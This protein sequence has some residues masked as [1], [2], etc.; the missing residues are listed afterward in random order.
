MNNNLSLGQIFKSKTAWTAVLAA[1]LNIWNT[2]SG[3][4]PPKV[5]VVG[6]AVLGLI[7]VL[8]RAFPTQEG[9]QPPI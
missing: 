1:T 2:T 4:L 7:T 6:N 3:M 8:F 9:T 5:V